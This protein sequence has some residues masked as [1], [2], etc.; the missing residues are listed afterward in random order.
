GAAANL[1]IWKK[2]RMSSYFVKRVLRIGIPFAGGFFLAVLP[3]AYISRDY[4]NCVEGETMSDNP[5]YFFDYFFENCFA[6]HGFKWLWFLALLA[7]MTGIHLPIIFLLKRA[8]IAPS[9]ELTYKL[10]NKLMLT[11]LCYILGWALFCGLAVPIYSFLNLGGCILYFTVCFGPVYIERVRN[12]DSS[13]ILL[14]VALLSTHVFVQA[15]DKTSLSENAMSKWLFIVISYIN[16]FL[17][18]FLV[19]MLENRIALCFSRHR[20]YLVL[21]LFNIA[22]LPLLAPVYEGSQDYVF[23]NGGVYAT[24]ERQDMRIIYGA[25]CYTSVLLIYAF[26]RKFLNDKFNP[27]AYDFFTR[28]TLPLYIVHPTIQ[29]FLAINWYLKY[30]KTW[31]TGI[32]FTTL[33]ALS[34]ALSFAFYILID[35]TPFRF[36][37]G[38]T[39]PSP[40]F[41]DGLF[42]PSPLFKEGVK[43]CKP[44]CG[45]EYNTSDEDE[46][47]RPSDNNDSSPLTNPNPAAAERGTMANVTDAMTGAVGEI[48]Y[49]TYGINAWTKVDVIGDRLRHN[50]EDEEDSPVSSELVEDAGYIEEFDED[51]ED[52]AWAVPSNEVWRSTVRE[53]RRLAERCRLLEGACKD[54]NVDLNNID[55][56]LGGRGG[57]GGGKTATRGGSVAMTEMSRSL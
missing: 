9:K 30:G 18:G 19:S 33:C 27:L 55:V 4:L 5:W 46:E 3:Y 7:L 48:F 29:Y 38:L 17:S 24:Y 35:V 44:W 39:G 14:L 2:T 22:L 21:S 36:L 25:G 12:A 20:G 54:N 10:H 40:L 43:L 51:D 6:Q 16:M 28:S 34:F 57:G 53:N 56:E 13:Y 31:S 23:V 15:D 52:D 26:A 32:T 41:P 42:K 50:Q 45:L 11:G 1:S 37:V 47:T 49:G 8:F